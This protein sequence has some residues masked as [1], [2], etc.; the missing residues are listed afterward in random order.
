AFRSVYK[1]K[2]GARTTF[3]RSNVHVSMRAPKTG[4]LVSAKSFGENLFHMLVLQHSLEN[5][6]APEDPAAEVN[7]NLLRAAL[8]PDLAPHAEELFLGRAADKLVKTIS[9]KEFARVVVER[10]RKHVDL[11]VSLAD[12]ES[13]VISLIRVV[14]LSVYFVLIL[15]FARIFGSNQAA[16]TLTWASLI[17]AVGFVFSG[18]TNNFGDCCLFVFVTRPF[19]VGDTIS[20]EAAGDRTHIVQ[21]IKLFSTV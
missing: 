7:A 9:K 1:E 5:E 6:D 14:R 12:Y 18:T 16:Q 17:F 21:G 3:D 10:C 19:D 15:I 8:G 4:E 2:T 13:I 11:V 20:M